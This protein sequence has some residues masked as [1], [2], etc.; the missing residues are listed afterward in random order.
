MTTTARFKKHSLVYFFAAFLTAFLGIA[1]AN[2]DT[3]AK[4]LDSWQLLPRPEGVSELYFA[5]DKKL[6]MAVRTES[7]HD[8]TFIIHNIEHKTT[9]YQ[10]K[11]VAIEQGSA[12]DEVLGVG[13]VELKHDE[14]KT[15]S[16]AVKIPPVDAARMAIQVELEYQGTSFGDQALGMQRQAIRYWVDVVGRKA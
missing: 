15:I 9:R 2:Q 7:S 6:P 10:Y 16:E 14:L 4:Q 13:G 11:L 12:T 8:V 3:I 5:D 1:T